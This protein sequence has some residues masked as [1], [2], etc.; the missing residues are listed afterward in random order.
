MKLKVSETIEPNKDYDIIFVF[1]FLL[2]LTFVFN[3]LLLFHLCQCFTLIMP[4]ACITSEVLV[5][6]VNVEESF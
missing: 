3:S 1:K 6:L 4:I 5:K 2:I